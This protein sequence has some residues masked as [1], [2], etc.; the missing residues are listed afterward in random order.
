LTAI[1]PNTA[2]FPVPSRIRPPLR[3]KSASRGSAAKKRKAKRGRS[4]GKSLKPRG[5][6][7]EVEE[8]YLSKQGVETI[9]H[10]DYSGYVGYAGV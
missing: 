8:V 4:I 1:S 10:E 2:I 6:Q 5:K 3:T 7:G 9:K